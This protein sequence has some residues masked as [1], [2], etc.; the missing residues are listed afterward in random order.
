MF[1]ISEFSRPV[2]NLPHVPVFLTAM[3]LLMLGYE[4]CLYCS[5][6]YSQRHTVP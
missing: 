6:K 4:I 5:V 2:N 1:A 3:Q